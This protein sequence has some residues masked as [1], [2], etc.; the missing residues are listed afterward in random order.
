MRAYVPP[1]MTPADPLHLFDVH[2]QIGHH[3]AH[4]GFTDRIA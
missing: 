4:I 3:H 2:T 1:L